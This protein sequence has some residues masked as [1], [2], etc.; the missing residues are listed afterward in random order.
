MASENSGWLGRS[1]CL[2]FIL[3]IVA[4]GR[5]RKW[6]VLWLN[7]MWMRVVIAADKDFSMAGFKPSASG[8]AHRL[9]PHCTIG[10]YADMYVS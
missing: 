8:T 4:V 9:G 6:A 1:E 7:S 3:P 2:R 10:C 5:V